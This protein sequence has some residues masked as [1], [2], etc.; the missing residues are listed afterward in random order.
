MLSPSDPTIQQNLP[1]IKALIMKDNVR[2]YFIPSPFLRNLITKGEHPLLQ[3]MPKA[4]KMEILSGEGIFIQ[5]LMVWKWL[6]NTLD[7]KN[8]FIL[9]N[10]EIRVVDTAFASHGT[11]ITD[12]GVS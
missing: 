10:G 8:S 4:R 6:S 9:S 1:K 11:L 5:K 7:K 3:Q 2:L 12:K